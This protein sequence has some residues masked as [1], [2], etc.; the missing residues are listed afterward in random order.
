MLHI[1]GLMIMT[2]VWFHFHAHITLKNQQN[3]SLL[4]QHKIVP[5]TSYIIA[6]NLTVIVSI[7]I[8]GNFPDV[9]WINSNLMAAVLHCGTESYIL[10]NNIRE[11]VIHIF[12]CLTLALIEVRRIRPHFSQSKTK[13]TIKSIRSKQVWNRR[14]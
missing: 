8:K 12:M 11:Q 9:K 7:G 13:R 2:R 6:I 3:C 5:F 14:S 10:I 1:F 4:W